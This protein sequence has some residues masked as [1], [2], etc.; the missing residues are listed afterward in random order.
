MRES[1]EQPKAAKLTKTTLATLP[2]LFL[3]CPLLLTACTTELKYID[4]VLRSEWSLINVPGTM[5]IGP[6]KL[7]VVKG[8]RDKLEHLTAP[9]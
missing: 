6:Y 3:G 5:G 8:L 7:L 9:K 1:K 2:S 4:C